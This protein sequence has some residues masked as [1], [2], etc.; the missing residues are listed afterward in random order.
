MDSPAGPCTDGR[1]QRQQPLRGKGAN[2]DGGAQPPLIVVCPANARG[3]ARRPIDR[4]RITVQPAI[5]CAPLPVT[6]AA[7]AGG[8]ASGWA[9]GGSLLVSL[10]SAAR[11][12]SRPRPTTERWLSVEPKLCVCASPHRDVASI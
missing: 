10:D 12:C 11:T 7:A 8:R 1:G 5:K 4:A 9:G 6:W 3:D 2:A